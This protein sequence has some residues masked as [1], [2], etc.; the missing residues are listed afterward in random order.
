[1]KWVQHMLPKHAI[2]NFTSDWTNGVAFCLLVNAISSDTIPKD[3]FADRN[4]N[5]I[6]VRLAFNAAEDELG[7][8]EVVSPTETANGLVDE[9]CMMTY[10]ALFRS[11]DKM[12]KRGQGIQ[13][14]FSSIFIY[15]KLLE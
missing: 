14:L 15:F 10:I 13:V 5:E 7:I 11:A 4:N 1:M 9:K 3:H 2:N 12:L 8:P 6:N